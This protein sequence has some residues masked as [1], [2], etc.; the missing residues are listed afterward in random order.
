MRQSAWLKRLV[1]IVRA[2]RPLGQVTLF[3]RSRFEEPNRLKKLPEPA[4]RHAPRNVGLQDLILHSGIGCGH[5]L[6]LLA[7]YVG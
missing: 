1:Y 5:I 3:V 2:K 4:R 6:F 7:T